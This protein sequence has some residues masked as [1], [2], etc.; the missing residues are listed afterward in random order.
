MQLRI[1]DSKQIILNQAWI[2]KPRQIQTAAWIF[3]LDSNKY[4][5]RH[6]DVYTQVESSSEQHLMASSLCGLQLLFETANSYQ[7]AVSHLQSGG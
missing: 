4:L 6:F 2:Y 1:T 3:S 5:K 7:E